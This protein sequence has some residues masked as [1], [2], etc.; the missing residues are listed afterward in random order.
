LPFAVIAAA[1]LGVDAAFVSAAVLS[2]LR[3]GAMAIPAPVL[4]AMPR[5]AVGVV[6]T[7]QMPT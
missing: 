3:I 7:S 4:E 2:P 5:S 1:V 6:A